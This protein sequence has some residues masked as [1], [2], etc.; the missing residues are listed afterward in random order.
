MTETWNF[1]NT[2]SHDPYYNMA[3]D[4]ALLNFVS[5]GEIDPVVRFYTWNPATLSVGYFQRLK[6]EIDIDKVNEKGF[7]LVRRQTGGKGVLHDKELTYSVIVSEEHPNMPSTVTEAYRVISEG[8]LEGF[9]L[10]GFEAYFAIPRSKEEREKLKQPRSAVCFD[11][12]SWYE[13]VVEG[14]KIA[15]S[16]QTRQK[17]VI[18]QH[19]SLLQD[20]NVDELFDMFIFKND[21]LK[22][23]MKKAFVD[24]AVAINDISDRHI[25]I[26]EMEK[27]FEEGFK[28]GLNIEFKP[29]TLSDEQIKE[30]KELEEKYRSDEWLYKK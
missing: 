21:R 24:K 28:K 1:I 11:A 25:S 26:E 16:A 10:L 30:V 18:L 3:M 27:A 17:G 12:P 15:G 19:G 4:E 29:L 14:R 13:L 8:L 9:K 5:R 6:K 23:K 2:G 22:D 20:V 7:G